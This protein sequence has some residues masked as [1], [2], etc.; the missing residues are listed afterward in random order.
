[1]TLR[2]AACVAEYERLL[3]VP[4]SSSVDT[5]EGRISSKKN[6][7]PEV[8]VPAKHILDRLMNPVLMSLHSTVLIQHACR[9]S[10]LRNASADMVAFTYAEIFRE[11]ST[12]NDFDQA[13]DMACVQS[14]H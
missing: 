6:C 13:I 5:I 14:L 9:T 4:H 2:F 3:E 11:A 10:C 12:C 8:D 1:V 7:N